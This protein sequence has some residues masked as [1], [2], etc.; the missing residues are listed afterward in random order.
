MFAL[1]KKKLSQNIGKE[2]LQVTGPLRR[3]YRQRFAHLFF[4]VFLDLVN[5]MQ[6]QFHTSYL[7]NSNSHLTKLVNVQ[8]ETVPNLTSLSQH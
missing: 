2:Y 4:V 7:L 3:L 8:E 1:A 6:Q 5:Q